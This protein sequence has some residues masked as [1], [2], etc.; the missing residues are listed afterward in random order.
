MMERVRANDTG[1][2]NRTFKT[3][4]VM[5]AFKD[6]KLW[7]IWLIS[8]TNALPTGGIGAFSNLIIKAFGYT[9]LQTYLLAIA[10]GVVIIAFLFSAAFLSKRFNQ[11][12]IL[13]AVFTIPNV[14]G[15]IVFLTVPTN[16][17]TKVGLLLSFYL[18]MAFGGVAILNLSVMSGNVA[19]RTKQVIGSSGVFITWAVGNAVGPQVFRANDAPRYFKAFWVHI[20]MYALQLLAIAGLRFIL[21]RG[22]RL[23]RKA[24]AERQGL[25]G[26][27][28]AVTGDENIKHEH[29]FEDLTDWENHECE[30]PI[31]SALQIGDSNALYLLSA[32]RYVY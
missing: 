9:Q 16:G 8:F 18:I 2:Q 17:S 19:G 3:Y 20:A 12:C 13:A 1:V 5:E 29:S 26:S 14:I 7:L 30:S 23:K 25:S 28:L 6:A 22:N 31:P 21:M 24:A 10:Q 15:T 27:T 4:Q 32:V 11:R